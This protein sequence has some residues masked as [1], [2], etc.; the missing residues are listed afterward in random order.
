MH[1]PSIVEVISQRVELRQ[2]GRELVGLCPFHEDRHPS[3]YVNPYKG[4]FLCRAC[5]ESGD[6][7]DFLMKLDGLSFPEAC[8]ALA[9]N[10]NDRP[11][12]P[13][14]TARRRRAAELAAAWVNGQRAKFNVL[15]ADAMEERDLA[16]EIGDFELAEIFDRE[17]TM[18][19]GFYDALEYSRGAAEMLALRPA[20]EGLTD[21]TR[22]AL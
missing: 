19:R 11:P 18:L 22:V 12:A 5:Q 3:L 17:L 7:I 4:V 21:G 20:I 15:I 8:R 6:V 2:S 10:G 14:L 16:D 1:K 13:T 9:I